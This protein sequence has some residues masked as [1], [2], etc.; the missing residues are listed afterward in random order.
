MTGLI[1]DLED[2]FR[3]SL[4][5]ALT[6]TAHSVS[7]VTSS[8]LAEGKTKPFSTHQFAVRVQEAQQL[9]GPRHCS[10]A[11]PDFPEQGRD[12]CR[13]GEG[14]KPKQTPNKKPPHNKNQTNQ[15]KKPTKPF[16]LP[17]QKILKLTIWSGYSRLESGFFIIML[18]LSKPYTWT[19]E[20][21]RDRPWHR[22]RLR[23]RTK[24]VQKGK[25]AY[26]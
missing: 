18:L 2:V 24:P 12:C 22:V 9:P 21:R 1:P 23:Q 7:T 20:G 8:S 13:K 5:P 3:P 19:L 6:P 14:K 11:K 4:P 15:P 26:H 16:S 25:A 10:A 17:L